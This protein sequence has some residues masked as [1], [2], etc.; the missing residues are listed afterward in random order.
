VIKDCI[1]FSFL[2]SSMRKI[3]PPCLSYIFQNL[4]SDGLSTSN[5]DK[6]KEH[7]VWDQERGEE[8]QIIFF[9]CLPSHI[10]K[11]LS[12]AFFS[13]TFFSDCTNG[14]EKLW[15]CLTRLYLLMLE[16]VWVIFCGVRIFLRPPGQVHLFSSHIRIWM[17]FQI[18]QFFTSSVSTMG[19]CRSSR[20]FTV[21]FRWRNKPAK[22]PFSSLV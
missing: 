7:K 21:F 12:F 1:F 8:K 4:V 2:S 10:K 16:Y 5:T 22:P 15:F 14:C 11:R 20:L 3:N 17:G 9:L 19:L 18:V 13:L 6:I